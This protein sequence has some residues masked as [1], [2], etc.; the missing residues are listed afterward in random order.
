MSP[1]VDAHTH[2]FPP[3]VAADREPFRQRDDWFGSLYGHPKATIATAEDLEAEM[4][5]AGVDASVA[6]A[7]GWK[8]PGLCAEH[9][10]YLLD[11]AR[12][13]GGRIL[14][15]V[16]IQPFSAGAVAEVHRCADRGARGIGE[17]MPNGQG[18]A[19]DD[20]DL[21]RPV[22]AA[23]AERHLP[24]L[25]HSSEPVGHAYPGKGSVTPDVLYRLARAFPELTII[26]AHWGGGLPF[27]ELMPEVQATLANVYYD[28]AASLFLYRPAVFQAALAAVAPRKVLFGSDFPLIR[29]G[30]FLNHVRKAG[31]AEDVLDAVLGGNAV[32]LLRL[33]EMAD[34]GKR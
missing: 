18:F 4:A 21:L 28:T 33:A 26:C 20:V 13:G 1:V 5:L 19:L 11:S 34:D 17:L 25:T 3:R 31:L 30:R 32:R 27:Y 22:L 14:P 23:A 10:D 16:A 8:D 24:V 15:F 12:L 29:Q 6:C 9:N 7:F 2:I